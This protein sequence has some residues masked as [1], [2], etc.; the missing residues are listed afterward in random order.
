MSRRVLHA[1]DG[2]SCTKLFSSDAVATHGC[3]AYLWKLSYRRSVQDHGGGLFLRITSCETMFPKLEPPRQ[4]TRVERQV[5]GGRSS[6]RASAMNWVR[7]PGARDRRM[8]RRRLSLLVATVISRSKRPTHTRSRVRKF[9][10]SP[11]RSSP[12]PGAAK[13]A[14]ANSIMSYDILLLYYYVILYYII[15]HHYIT[16][17]YGLSPGPGRPRRPRRPPPPAPRGLL[18]AVYTYLYIYIYIMYIY[19]YICIHISLSIHMYI[20]IY[21]VYERGPGTL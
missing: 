18:R 1:F 6:R 17:G 4:S 16:P 3:D 7:D 10:R 11:C 13:A 19:I 8:S 14:A 20:Y 12:S 2:V 15:L 21:I 5:E 9:G